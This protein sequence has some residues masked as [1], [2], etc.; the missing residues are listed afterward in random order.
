[1]WCLHITQLR[2]IDNIEDGNIT[3]EWYTPKSP[4][5]SKSNVL[6]FEKLKDCFYR[7]RKPLLAEVEFDPNEIIHAWELE[8]DEIEAHNASF[9]EVDYGILQGKLKTHL[10]NQQ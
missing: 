8:G 9:T 6:Q 1:M 3:Y 4:S 2:N 5:F 7:D 10:K